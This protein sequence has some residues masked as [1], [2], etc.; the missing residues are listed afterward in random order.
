MLM[1][2]TSLVFIFIIRLR[3]PSKVSISTIMI[4]AIITSSVHCYYLPFPPHLQTLGLTLQ[5]LGLSCVTLHSFKSQ[6]AR[7][8]ALTHFKSSQS[9]LLV[10]TDLASRGLDIPLVSL[11]NYEENTWNNFYISVL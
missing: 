10:A 6:S 9:K 1:F 7:L 8:S 5:E 4:F 3:F 11:F 2:V